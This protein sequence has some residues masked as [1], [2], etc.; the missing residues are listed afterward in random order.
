MKINGQMHYLWRAVN[1]EGEVLE[2]YATQERDKKAALKFI[3]K[4]M[5]RHSCPKTI[6]TDG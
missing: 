3:K 2:S 5:K 6:T 1:H 4:L